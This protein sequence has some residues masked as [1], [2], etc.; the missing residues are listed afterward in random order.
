MLRSGTTPKR[1]IVHADKPP[2]RRRMRITRKPSSSYPRSPHSSPP[3]PS[4]SKN[5]Q[6]R[7]DITHANTSIAFDASKGKE[8]RDKGEPDASVSESKN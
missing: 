6:Q 2:D 5:G 4:S 3:P 1:I 8:I 7:N